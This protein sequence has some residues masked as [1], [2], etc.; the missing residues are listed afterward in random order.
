MITTD[1]PRLMCCVYNE[2]VSN[3][4]ATAN[5]ATMTTAETAEGPKRL[6]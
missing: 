3:G 2:R 6:S 4:E 5:V 1:S